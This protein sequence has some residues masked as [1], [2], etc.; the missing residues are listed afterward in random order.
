MCSTRSFCRGASGGYHAAQVYGAEENLAKSTSLALSWRLASSRKRREKEQEERHGF[1]AAGSAAYPSIHSQPPSSPCSPS[2]SSSLLLFPS[3]FG[4]LFPF[5]C[6]H[7]PYFRPPMSI[8]AH[9]SPHSNT[10]CRY[11]FSFSHLYG[12]CFTG[13]PGW[14][15]GVIFLFFLKVYLGSRRLP[16]VGGREL[17]LGVWEGDG[18]WV[19]HCRVFMPCYA[20]LLL[21]R[22]ITITS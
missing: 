4:L 17:G 8:L 5:P 20:Q 21:L 9:V 10:R 15:E 22:C 12:I 7:P 16:G 1:R 3:P 6:H 19:V 18:A 14:E 2:S 11:F 13:I